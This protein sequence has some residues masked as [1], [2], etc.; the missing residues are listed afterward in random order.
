MKFDRSRA[1]RLIAAVS[2]CGSIV[3][4]KGARQIG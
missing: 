1:A 2:G 4:A 3:G